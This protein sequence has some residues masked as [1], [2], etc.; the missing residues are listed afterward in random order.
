MSGVPPSSE[1][2]LVNDRRWYVEGRLF[3]QYL[4]L[5]FDI[6]NGTGPDDMRFIFGLTTKLDTFFSRR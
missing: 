2:D 5:G 3:L 1:F 4:Y 6:N